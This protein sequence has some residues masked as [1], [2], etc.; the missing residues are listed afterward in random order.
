M[1]SQT[2]ARDWLTLLEAT[3]IVYLLEPYAK[4][5]TKR[6][7]KSPKLF[8]T[9]TGLLCYLLPIETMEQLILF[10]FAGHIFENM[11]LMDVVKQFVGRGKRAPCYFYRTSHGHEV[12]LI[13]DKGDF[14]DAYEIKFTTNPKIE[15]T[16]ALL[17][18]KKDL[19]TRHIALLNLYENL[20]PF[21]NGIIAQHWSS[22]LNYEF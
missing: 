1:F 22:I 7:V 20:Y 21:S 18:E 3:S 11:V 15:M 19:P 2:T 12:D 8:F 10:P 9:D 13:I 5:I 16:E 4:T 14:V 17:K 6:V